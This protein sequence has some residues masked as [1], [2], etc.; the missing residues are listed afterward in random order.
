MHDYIGVFNEDTSGIRQ[1]TYRFR[2]DVGYDLFVTI[3]SEQQ[4]I[5][6]KI[7][8]WFTGEPTIIIWPVIGMRTLRS[9][10]RITL[11]NNLWAEIRSRSSTARRKLQVIGGTIDSGYRGEYFTVLHN[12]GFIPRLIRDG[13]RYAQVVFF[14]AKRPVVRHL[15]AEHFLDDQTDRGDAGFGSTG[16]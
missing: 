16:M 11:P 7:V 13:Q 6:D 2:G 8:S 5:F 15:T 10:L 14:E 9:G 12:F 1:F 4:T 3:D